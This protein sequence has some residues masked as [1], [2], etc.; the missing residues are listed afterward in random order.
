MRKWFSIACL[1]SVSLVVGVLQAQDI[2]VSPEQ[3]SGIYQ[4]GETAKWIIELKA[5]QGQVTDAKF[6]VKKGGQTVAAQGALTFVDG[7][8]T[9]E[10]ANAEPGWLLLEVNAKAG[11]KKIQKLGGAV[12]SPEKIQ[13]SAPK[14]D[15]F[16]AFWAEKLSELAKVP[17]DAVLEKGE[18]GKANVDYYTITMNNIRG[19]HVRGQLARPTAGEKFPALLIVQWAGVYRL[20][21]AWVADRAAEG[22][23]ALNIQAHDLPPT[24][25]KD[26]YD[27]QNAGPLKDYTGIG[28]DDRETSYFLRMYLSCYRAAEYLTTR[29]DW[30]GKV[31]VVTG[32]SQGGL[33]TIVTAAIFPKVTGAVANVPAGC[34]MTALD[35]GRMIGWPYWNYQTK[36]KDPAKVKQASRYFDVVNF[37]SKVKCPILVGVG[38][39]DT[40]CPPTGV[41][42]ALNQM[43]CPKEVVFMPLYGHQGKHEAFYGRNGP[44]MTALKAGKEPP[45]RQ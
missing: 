27:K 8:A 26:F 44:W 37:A 2:S 21:K 30:N 33:Q 18:A 39:I 13:P 34:D 32:G 3:K 41:Y 35:A 7:K 25:P 15:D 10:A 19:T 5:E 40:T 14:P 17:T 24:E 43:T 38:G 45:I 20:E 28:N 1:A 4:A 31:L 22:W 16:D 12:F 29:P 11:E 42:A 36:G 6:T 23:L 9:V